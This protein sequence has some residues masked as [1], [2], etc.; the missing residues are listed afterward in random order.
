[1]M[2][3]SP[4]FELQRMIESVE[5]SYEAVKAGLGWMAKTLVIEKFEDAP[6]EIVNALRHLRAAHDELMILYER[7]DVRVDAIPLPLTSNNK[8]ATK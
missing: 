7:Y 2:T 8:E 3:Y 1:M 4:E 6:R 5:N